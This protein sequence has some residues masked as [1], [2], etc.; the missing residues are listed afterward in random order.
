MT[1]E[2]VYTKLENT[3]Q[4]AFVYLK[5]KLGHE[6]AGTLFFF[7]T[8]CFFFVCFLSFLAHIDDEAQERPTEHAGPSQCSLV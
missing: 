5:S 3:F 7:F 2:I 6:P 8:D 4:M 1:C